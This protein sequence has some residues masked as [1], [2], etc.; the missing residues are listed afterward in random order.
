VF[1]IPENDISVEDTVPPWEWYCK[2]ELSRAC[3]LPNNPTMG[4]VVKEIRAWA[5]DEAGNNFWHEIPVTVT[6]G[7]SRDR[8]VIS[9]FRS[10]LEKLNIGIVVDKKL[11]IEKYGLQDVD[12]VKFTAAKIFMGKQTTIWDNDLSDGASASFDV[13][14]GFYKITTT[15]Y[16]EDK[17]IS[18]D[19]VS[20]VIFFKK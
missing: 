18:T 11:N 17:E 1:E 12:T 8:T 7:T 19:L 20:R 14:S 15:T 6:W 10:I 16:K 5:Y 4:F 9:N 13:P 3:A 2:E